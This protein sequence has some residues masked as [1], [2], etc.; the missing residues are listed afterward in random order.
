[1]GGALCI[2]KRHA[3]SHRAQPVASQPFTQESDGTS[4]DVLRLRSA[5]SPDTPAVPGPPALK[6]VRTAARGHSVGS[7]SDITTCK[8]SVSN[9]PHSALGGFVRP[10]FPS[11][12]SSMVNSQSTRAPPHVPSIGMTEATATAVPHSVSSIPEMEMSVNSSCS[13]F[14]LYSADSSAHELPLPPPPLLERA[15]PLQAVPTTAA[16]SA[17]RIKASG[18]A[19]Q[20][21]SDISSASLM[22]TSLLPNTATPP[23]MLPD[24]SMPVRNYFVPQNFRKHSGT[25]ASQSPGKMPESD[26]MQSVAG[27]FA[28]SSSMTATAAA[29]HIVSSALLDFSFDSRA[30]AVNNAATSTE[31]QRLGVRLRELQRGHHELGAAK[32]VS[33]L[34]SSRNSGSNSASCTQN[35]FENA[36][37]GISEALPGASTACLELSP[38][39]VEPSLSAQEVAR[40]QLHDETVKFVSLIQEMHEARAAGQAGYTWF[41]WEPVPPNTSSGSSSG[42]GSGPGEVGARSSD[43]TGASPPPVPEKSPLSGNRCED[44]PVGNTANYL[45]HRSLLRRRDRTSTRV[46]WLPFEMRESDFRTGTSITP[47]CFCGYQSTAVPADGAGA[48]HGCEHYPVMGTDV[49]TTHLEHLLEA[50]ASSG[51][52]LSVADTPP[53]PSVTP[54]ARRTSTLGADVDKDSTHYFNDS[55]GPLSSSAG[56]MSTS[57]HS[58]SSDSIS[59]CPIHVAH[60]PASILVSAKGKRCESGS[61]PSLPRRSLLEPTQIDVPATATTGLVPAKLASAQLPPLDPR[62]STGDGS[63]CESGRRLIISAGVPHRRQLAKRALED[64]KLFFE[65]FSRQ[66][67]FS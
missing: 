30:F 33:A 51:A 8:N 45:R 46:Q 58:F 21:P 4:R 28:A 2:V 11:S 34:L 32:E 9:Y 38:K 66:K 10:L 67:S 19:A 55:K 12:S 62:R 40:K 24:T 23:T 53:L 29:A 18:N 36:S 43:R 7:S 47:V 26:P 39:S 52:I 60:R 59:F 27:S 50:G 61:F 31:I 13:A 35:L 41:R 64:N 14:S 6:S 54:L 65:M 42:G 17:T 3:S 5:A 22:T 37:K 56:T 48:T 25:A 57:S 16:A 63:A 44:V 20:Y 49:L 1:M 15:T